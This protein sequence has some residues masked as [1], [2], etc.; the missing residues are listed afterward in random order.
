[1]NKAWWITIHGD[2]IDV[3][4]GD[5]HDQIILDNPKK[6]NISQKEIDT[7]NLPTDESEESELTELATKYGNI[8]IRLLYGGILSGLFI[9]YNSKTCKNFATK[10]M[11]FIYDKILS[12]NIKNILKINTILYDFAINMNSR[13]TL[14]ELL[15]DL[16]KKSLYEKKNINNILNKLK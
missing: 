12:L 2:V 1:V 10:L 6:F 3:P 16:E 9:E 13:Q 7:L 15:S 4:E 11:N 8:R 5:T 14:N